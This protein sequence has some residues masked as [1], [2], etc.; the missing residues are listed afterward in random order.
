MLPTLRPF[1]ALGCCLLLTAIISGCNPEALLVE[2]PVET[3]SR[4]ESA[5]RSDQNI[6]VASFNIQ[7]FGVS[8]MG[9]PEAV[10]ILVDIA[11]RFDV[12]AIQELRSADQTVV[13]EFVELINA[14]G[15]QYEYVVGPRLGRTQSKEQYVYLYDTARIELA[16]QSVYTVADPQDL[17]H[18]EPLV[19]RFRVRGP[20]ADEAFT[21]SL[22]NIHTDPDDTDIELDA[23]AD[24]FT[25]VQ[26]NRSGE[27]DVILLGDLNVD[28]HDL[29]RLGEL[30]GITWT[31]S[32]EPTNT[33][34]TETYDNLVFD[35]RYTTEFTGRSGVMN[36]QEA[37]GLT[38]D[39]ALVV[40]DHF[41]VW[42][43]FVPSEDA[44]PR[45]ARGRGSS[46]TTR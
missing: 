40:S 37:Y 46:G 36:L 30:P 10:E 38:L 1:Q 15:S 17:L 19:A 14:D 23:L 22:A 13:P 42:A 41:P 11:R 35:S 16:P 28:R 26:N 31:V 9:K 43:E 44:A 25:A 21:F 2:T 18:R 39:E 12:L 24:V 45:V 32:E 3:S 8:K 7:V 20:P 34:E 6:A 4:G 33:R 27:D 29:G 5:S